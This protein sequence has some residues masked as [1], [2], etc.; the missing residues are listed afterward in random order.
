MTDTKTARHIVRKC[1]HCNNEG[2]RLDF[3]GIDHYGVDTKATRECAAGVKPCKHHRCYWA[4]VA[5]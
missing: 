2:Y 4:P 3:F 1:E 5:R